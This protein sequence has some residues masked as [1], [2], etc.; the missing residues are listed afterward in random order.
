M[1]E[2]E[3][4][5]SEQILALGRRVK[6]Q[7]A[8]LKHLNETKDFD[9]ISTRKRVQR[10]IEVQPHEQTRMPM[11]QKCGYCGSSHPSRRC[12]AYGK[13][14]SIWKDQLLQG[15]LQKWEEKRYTARLNQALI[16]AVHRG[17]T[18]ND[19]FPKL[20]NAQYLVI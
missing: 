3:N 16:R 17:L 1:E 14:Y 5:R 19:I 20:N 12:P 4:V 6:A 13:T 7:S 9:K 10:Q 8:I 11:K 2:N 18:L 15:G